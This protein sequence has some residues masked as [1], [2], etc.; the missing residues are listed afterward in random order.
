MGPG[1]TDVVPAGVRR[2][3]YGFVVVISFGIFVVV[4]NL[5]ERGSVPFLTD[6]LETL[7]PII[8]TALVASMAINI[9]WIIYDA[10][11]FRSAGKIVLNIL[12]IVALGLTLR[13]FP[14]DF[15]PYEFDWE[16]VIRIA[17]IAI[18]VVL[19]IATAVEIAKLISARTSR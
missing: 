3:G 12:G 4:N 13:V 14:F 16:T 5:L 7:L 15:S 9:V 17:I 18:I 8:N 1:Q 11:W 19:A 10:P 6:D 2:L